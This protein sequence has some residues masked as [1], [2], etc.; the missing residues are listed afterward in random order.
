MSLLIEGIDAPITCAFCDHSIY[1]GPGNMYCKLA[2]K[3]EKTNIAS[4]RRADFCPMKNIKEP[5]GRLGD[6]DALG[7]K[8]TEMMQEPDYQHEGENWLVGLIMAS[9]AIQ[10]TE[11]IIEAEGETE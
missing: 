8:I 11:T 6:L 1:V 3:K 7:G 4:K 2:C 10:E 5:H 9:D